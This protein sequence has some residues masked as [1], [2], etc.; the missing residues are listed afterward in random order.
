MSKVEQIEAELGKLS[1]SELCQIRNW[2]DDVLE[3]GL[4]FKPEFEAAIQKSESE[5][6]KGISS[7]VREP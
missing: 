1:Q 3:D 7:R 5:M 4:E 2:L 6:A